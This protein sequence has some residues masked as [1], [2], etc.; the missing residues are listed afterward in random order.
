MALPPP[1][2]QSPQLLDVDLAQSDHG[3][4][5]LLLAAQGGYVDCVNALL[6]AGA[7]I[8]RATTTAGNTPVFIAAQNGHADVIMVRMMTHR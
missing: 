4:T 1:S 7:D 3:A 5:A 8:N 2:P 6:D